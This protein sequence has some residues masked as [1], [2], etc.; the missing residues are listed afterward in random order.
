MAFIWAVVQ[1]YTLAVI[2]TMTVAVCL[3]IVDMAVNSKG[4]GSDD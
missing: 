3:L 2:L 1:G 4:R